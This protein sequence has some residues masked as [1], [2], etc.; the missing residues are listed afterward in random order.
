M[1]NRIPLVHA[2]GELQELPASDSLML[3]GLAMAAPTGRVA[4]G[5]RL[6]GGRELVSMR[7]STWGE[8]ALQ[9]RLDRLAIA[10]WRAIGNIT[11]LVAE[12]APAL[13]A[14]GTVTARAVTATSLASRARRVGAISAAT[15]GSLAGWYLNTVT[16]APMWKI[17]R[18]HV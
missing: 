7:G 11:T 8:E 14:I 2:N 17:G 16:V 5:A 13:T 4:I 3:A 9:G 18:A 15:T 10:R 1:A 6:L 12:G